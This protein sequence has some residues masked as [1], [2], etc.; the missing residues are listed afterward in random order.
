MSEERVVAGRNP[1][2]QRTIAGAVIAVVVAVTG[3]V[4]W[5]V[6]HA[7]PP[8][9]RAGARFV[10]DDVVRP[11]HTASVRVPWGQLDLGVTAPRRSLPRDAAHVAGRRSVSAPPAGAFVGVTVHAG[12][13]YTADRVAAV[14]P[15]PQLDTVVSLVVDGRR[16][17][18]AAS[19][20]VR[21][22]C[23]RTCVAGIE[24]AQWVAVTG[25]TTKL[26]FAVT[27]GG[28]TQTVDA[29]TGTVRPGRAT[30]LYG[31]RTSTPGCAEPRWSSG[32]AAQHDATCE[33]TVTRTAYL[34]GLGWAPS[35]TTW[36]GVELDLDPP[37]EVQRR[38]GAAVAD[39]SVLP[40][41][42]TVDYRL[43]GASPVYRADQP[44]GP[45]QLGPSSRRSGVADV[46][47]F[48]VPVAQA[49]PTLTVAAHYL[50]DSGH[51]TATAA[52]SRATETWTVTA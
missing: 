5:A 35:G 3:V 47:A 10:A 28:V 15:T 31:S 50:L 12:N 43:Q 26:G 11:A 16:F 49:L 9:T 52:N 46:V 30:G 21:A 29:R 19:G 1:R 51:E 27:Y 44:A 18:L 13:P 37:Y 7:D 40:A 41:G 32:F 33:L 24:G 39:E 38:D 4:T 6:V 48:R 25:D 36:I 34:A 42:I 8:R 45:G 2:T 17:P 14:R 23:L 20:R 22:A